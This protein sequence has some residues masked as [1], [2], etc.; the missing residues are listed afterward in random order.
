MRPRRNAQG[1]SLVQ[2]LAAILV[3]LLLWFAIAIV[4]R[5]RFQFTIR[6]L[7]LLTVIVSIWGSWFGIETQKAKR[8]EASVEAL[9]K[10]DALLKYDFL[11]SVLSAHL[12]S[13]FRELGAG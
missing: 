1:T 12:L 11:Y 5:R 8:Q 2:G 4:F 6:S 13:I 10:L 7:L 9:R 3:L